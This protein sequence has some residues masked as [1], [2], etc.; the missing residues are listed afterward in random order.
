[1]KDISHEAK[2][3]LAEELKDI[4]K[5]PNQTPKSVKF[6]LEGLKVDGKVGYDI[7]QDVSQSKANVT[8]GELLK[9][10]AFYRRQLRPL[11]TGKKRKFKLPPT[12][13]NLAAEEVEDLGAPDIEVQVAGC[14]IRKVPVDGGS[15]VNILIADTAR[16][17]GFV[18]FEPTPKVLRM[19]DQSRVF[20][21]G[22]IS[23]LSIIIGDKP[24]R[25]NFL[26]LEPATPSTF[27]MLLGR[28][29]LYKAKVNTSWGDKTF[30][31]GHPKTKITWET[32]VHQGETSSTDEGYNS[33]DSSST[34]ESQWIYQVK[35][36]EETDFQWESEVRF[37]EVG[38]SDSDDDD[39]PNLSSIFEIEEEEDTK[40]DIQKEEPPEEEKE[41]EMIGSKELK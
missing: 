17:L 29:W 1:M 22:K 15:G 5:P 27:P 33:D 13:V 37:L 23:N 9:E 24:F 28:P 40:E 35:Q 36:F 11:L 38:T 31:F 12:L 26:V 16:A 4:P 14:L 32:I 6:N 30:T 20:P 18:N 3:I 2:D 10:N 8:I 39:T 34:I 25:L 19:A 41:E 21:I 7:M